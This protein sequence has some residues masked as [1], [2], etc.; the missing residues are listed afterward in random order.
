[1]DTKCTHFVCK[2]CSYFRMNSP[3][4]R[5][6]IISFHLHISLIPLEIVTWANWGEET[7]RRRRQIYFP[8]RFDTHIR[9]YPSSGTNWFN[10]L[11]QI[12]LKHAYKC[13][14]PSDNDRFNRLQDMTPIL[15]STES[16]SSIPS[17]KGCSTAQQWC[18]C[19]HNL[20]S[21]QVNY[22]SFRDKSQIG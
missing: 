1:M 15:L 12:R 16:L 21:R 14:V 3:Y 20:E 4:F 10:D 19:D 17:T 6:N 9:I 11:Y 13:Q 22:H 18:Q 7:R 5:Q 8:P 2:A